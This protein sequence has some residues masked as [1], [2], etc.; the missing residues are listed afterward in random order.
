MTRRTFAAL[1]GS[2]VRAV[3]IG[4]P[5]PSR[6]RRWVADR[7]VG[8]GIMVLLALLWPA[9]ARAQTT[10]VVEYYHTDALGSVRAVPNQ[11]GVVIRRHDFLP[12]GEEIQ[13]TVPPPEKRLFTGKERD[14]ETGLDYFGARYNSSSF[15][16]FTSVDPVMTLDENLVDPQRWN[17][18]AYVRNNPLRWTDPNGL[19]IVNCA[20][21]D[22]KCNAAAERFED[23]RMRN[24]GSDNRDVVEAALAFGDPGK[25]N[26]VSVSFNLWGRDGLVVVDRSTL[27]HPAIDVYINP[28]LDGVD[29]AQLVAHE[30]THVRDDLNYIESGDPKFNLTLLESETRAFSVGA[31]VQ[32]YTRGGVTFGPSEASKIRTYLLND[33]YY[34]PR[35]KQ[36]VFVW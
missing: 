36:R 16:R 19:Y 25:A 29:L 31:R 11:S 10:Q 32:P 28:T 20:S 21:D 26:G 24:L 18:Y 8:V 13:P 5:S 15:G 2:V 33:P 6:R 3:A 17:R 9:S 30:G 12:F 35:A 34:G 1:T 4:T 14:V 22:K 7:L 23:S 27:H